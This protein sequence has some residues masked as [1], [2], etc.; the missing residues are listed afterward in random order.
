MTIPIKLF[1]QFIYESYFLVKL[2]QLLNKLKNYINLFN[3]KLEYKLT[4]LGQIC[5]LPIIR[6][7][8]IE[9]FSKNSINVKY[10]NQLD[11]KDSVAKGLAYYNS[12]L[13]GSWKYD[14]TDTKIQTEFEEDDEKYQ[15]YLRIV[16]LIENDL[17]K[18]D[19]MVKATNKLKYDL[20]ARIYEYRRE[21][22]KIRGENKSIIGTYLNEC[23]DWLKKSEGLIYNI[24]KEKIN[25][26]EDKWNKLAVPNISLKRNIIYDEIQPYSN[27]NKKYK[28]LSIK[29]D[30]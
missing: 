8:I 28:N 15:N 21:S 1:N 16:K 4:L 22:K 24:I 30:K 10:E 25:E 2:Y 29:K 12:I 23:L 6:N 13:N 14:I 26:L 17:T 19:K 7:N 9:F 3:N 5:R 27:D 11:V 18:Q 20:E